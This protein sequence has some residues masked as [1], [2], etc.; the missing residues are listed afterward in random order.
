MK[1]DLTFVVIDILPQ[2]LDF[3]KVLLIF[4]TSHWVRNVF[5]AVMLRFSLYLRQQMNDASFFLDFFSPCHAFFDRSGAVNTIHP[6][7]YKKPERT[8]T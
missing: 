8:L 2:S 7:E 3:R 5:D 1:Y 6:I 4:I